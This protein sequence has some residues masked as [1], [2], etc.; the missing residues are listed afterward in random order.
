M[1]GAWGMLHFPVSLMNRLNQTESV[2]IQLYRFTISEL[3]LVSK[4]LR[5][6]CLLIHLFNFTK[7]IWYGYFGSCFNLTQNIS[8]TCKVDQILNAYRSTLI[9]MFPVFGEF[10]SLR[11][12]LKRTINPIINIQWHARS[13]SKPLLWNLLKLIKNHEINFLKMNEE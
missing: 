11:S 1:V 7:W 12:A 9:R 6:I 8:I 4:S 10:F 13:K 2:V 5:F 3:S